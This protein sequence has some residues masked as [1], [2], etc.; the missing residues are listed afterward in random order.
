[1]KFET[2]E[3]QHPAGGTGQKREN[4][5]GGSDDEVIDNIS[6]F[7]KKMLVNQTTPGL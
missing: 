1:M 2:A 3:G 6:T 4:P 7:L 5:E